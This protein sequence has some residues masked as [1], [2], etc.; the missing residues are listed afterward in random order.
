MPYA[1]VSH[2]FRRLLETAAA[3]QCAVD[4]SLVVPCAQGVRDC[5]G[6]VPGE[7]CA[8]YDEGYQEPRQ[9]RW[10]LAAA[11]LTMA[12]MAFGMGAND[13]ANAWGTSV[14]SGAIGMFKATLVG[15]LFDWLGTVTLGAGVSDT[16]RKGVADVSDPSCWA[17]G[18]CDSRMSLYMLGM[19]LA[20]LGT[21]AFLLLA[22]F[23]AMPVSVT[24]AIVG[25][26]VGMTL[27]GTDGGCLNL[28]S[29]GL[30]AASWVTSP[31][32][33]GAIGSGMYVLLHRHVILA[34]D[35][36]QAALSVCPWLYA[37]TTAAMTALILLKSPLTAHLR[38]PWVLLVT[39]AAF[40]LAM[41][42]SRQLVVPAIRRRIHS[43]EVE[44]RAEEMELADAGVGTFTIADD[45]ETLRSDASDIGSPA[46]SAGLAGAAHLHRLQRTRDTTA[47]HLLAKQVSASDAVQAAAHATPEDAEF[48]DIWGAVLPSGP[49]PASPRATP[50]IYAGESYSQ[51]Q[52]HA[53]FVFRY[54]LVFVAALES[55]AHGANDSGNA[56]GAF[57]A[58]WLTY[59]NGVSYC[60][61]D[62]TPTWILVMAGFFVFLG[63]VLLGR[64]VIQTVGFGLTNINFLRGFCIE[65][66]STASV[67][68]A[69]IMGLPVSTTHCQVGAV[70]FVGWTSF[71]REA[72]EWRLFGW[73]V[74]T[75]LVT[76]PT[77]GG[78]TAAMT[79]LMDRAIS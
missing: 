27:V 24:H 8:F 41:L 4:Q 51:K 73:I 62:S 29:I 44:A 71:G 59:Q 60:D 25:A 55:F 31:L 11:F 48:D 43:S 37:T 61:L 20:L 76:L 39:G 38:W 58:V 64:R 16:I 40:V 36:E 10:V 57:S 56:T 13:A 75:W 35:A 78:L 7:A 45:E 3:D 42:I 47:R 77:A 30:I 72:V 18:Y 23:T 74:L 17:C 32:L 19:A 46:S 70:I 54:L 12:L 50:G 6:E 5:C 63:V 66:A 1:L 69:T 15:G 65:F 14:G 53:L 22:T 9:L 79:A 33:S 52:H 49:A 26:V 34:A 67:V 21:A 68:L 28:R 2:I